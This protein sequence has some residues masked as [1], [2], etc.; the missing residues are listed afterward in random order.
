VVQPILHLTSLNPHVIS[1]LPKKHALSM[2]R[3]AG[4]NAFDPFCPLWGVSAFAFQGTN[5]HAV[6]AAPGPTQ[7]P[8]PASTLVS[9]AWGKASCW[10][11]PEIHALINGKV[12]SRGNTVIFQCKLQQAKHGYLWDHAVQGRPLL[13][14]AAFLELSSACL[15]VI[16][17]ISASDAAVT[18]AAIAV[19]LELP[20]PAGSAGVDLH[21]SLD[22]PTGQMKVASMQQGGANTSVPRDH[23]YAKAGLCSSKTN[24]TETEPEEEGPSSPTSV[25]ASCFSFDD[26][27]EAAAMGEID[28]AAISG[29]QSHDGRGAQPAAVDAAFHL[30]ALPKG[31]EE[32]AP[33]RVPATI[34]GYTSSSRGN[35]TRSSL[36]GGC[37]MQKELPRS[38][39]NSYFLRN[40]AGTS[41]CS[42]SGL[43]AK[44][45]SAAA[46]AVKAPAV[47]ASNATDPV[48]ELYCTSWQASL[49]AENLQQQS[50]L[51]SASGGLEVAPTLRGST[52]EES[53]CATGLAALQQSS[54]G[55]ALSISGRSTPAASIATKCSQGGLLYG[56][57]KAAALENS[58]AGYSSYDSDIQSMGS[59]KTT[60][61]LPDSA[62][63]TTAASSVADFHGLSERSRTAYQPTLQA[64]QQVASE[65][66]SL[67]SLPAFHLFPS[68]RGALNNLAALPVDTA[69][70]GAG[71]VVMAVKAVGI[72]FRDVLNVLGMYPGDPGPPGGDC[73]G[74]V[75]SV[76]KGVTHLKPGDAVFG[77]AAGSLGSHVRV[78][79]ARLAP[80]P[81][82]L[83]F[84]ATAST[85]TV[86][87]TVDMAFRQAGFV[88]PKERVLVHAAAGGVG[89]AAIQQ[90]A[91]LGGE[92]IAT[93]GSTNKR[94]LV[95]SLGAKAALGSRDTLF[96]SE[97]AEL[98][99]ADVVLNSLTS[100]GMVAGSLSG[101]KVGG[102]FVEIS[103]RDIWSPARVAQ[104][105]P[106]VLYNLVAVDFL[107]DRAVHSALVRLGSQLAAGTLHPLPQV[108][109]ELSAVQS[110]LRQMSQA[111]HVGKIVVMA[112]SEQQSIAGSVLVTGGLGTLGSLTSAWLASS[113]SKLAVHA[114]GRTGRFSDANELSALVVA[115]Q[116]CGE[117]TLTS[118]DAS[119]VEDARMLCTGRPVVGIM[120]ASGVLA[121]A[122]L[123]NQT[124]R[125][126]RTVYAPKVAA[127]QRLSGSTA[128]HPG[129]FQVLFSSVAALFGS[130][131]Q[132]NYSSANIWLDLAA[133]TAESK[134]C[135]LFKKNQLHF[136]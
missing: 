78:P 106:D 136:S 121:D 109:H 135:I 58:A 49:P 1:T 130:A 47:T 120:H 23:I 13:P 90:A 79:A 115:G 60:L 5:A 9:K 116:F 7:T 11:A 129:A 27:I 43:E 112:P 128:A 28:T 107:P 18:H 132:A 53:L 127:L 48:T 126:V 30:G 133:E 111:R 31:A 108:V 51:L 96:V 73:A 76:G 131:G 4:T 77:L 86:F 98:S 10:F 102:R 15:H 56:L 19:P 3:Q 34:D 119:C 118:A 94:N 21:L 40:G 87:I 70:P 35:T 75:L 45:F 92:V 104:E 52:S 50:T 134:V 100:S 20:V 29:A 36:F 39:V 42:V 25:L 64:L 101:L 2:P 83:S 74:V 61:T 6:L 54:F 38:V 117:V 89:L 122:T 80:V 16:S 37:K 82:T 41:M 93:A 59:A 110:A 17:S 63:N 32:K 84:E 67:K 12:Y 69:K 97:L 95:R 105:R 33:L 91:A 125:G 99:G 66:A 68:P 26:F 62:L 114:T 88:Q 46:S 57:L 81:S 65:G 14:G 22:L 24:S 55:A 85:P 103:K 72:N 113:S 124:L 44:L 71:E 8:G 123:R